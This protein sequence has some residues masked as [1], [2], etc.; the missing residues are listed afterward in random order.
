M[1]LT[2]MFADFGPSRPQQLARL[3]QAV[4]FCLVVVLAF[5]TARLTWNLVP[6]PT[7]SAPALAVAMPVADERDQ[8]PDYQTIADWHL[9]GE[10]NA[11]GPAPVQVVEAPETRLN[12]KLAGILHSDTSAQARAIIGQSGSP[13]RVYKAGDNIATGVELA[14]IERDRVILSRGGRLESLSLPVDDDNTSSRATGSV[15][16][17]LPGSVNAA[18]ESAVNAGEVAA[19]IRD[20][21]EED[22]GAALAQVALANPYVQNG[23]FVGF[24]LRPG[25][26]R[27]MLGQLGLRS[28]DVV[29]EVNGSRLSSPAQGLALMQG[30]MNAD[31]IA[32]KVLRN[33]EE[34]PFTFYLNQ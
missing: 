25:R 26:D 27:R 6:R 11:A 10:A 2:G 31:Q 1:S 12:L 9:F 18:D 3:A 22:P 19:K 15:S 28:G 7:P 34:I 21:L 32:V 14:A 13:E 5:Q 23:Q 17:S 24:R 30:L 29:T 8:T 16:P 20:Q 33:G 4:T